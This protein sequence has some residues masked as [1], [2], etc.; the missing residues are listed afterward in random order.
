MLCKLFTT[1]VWPCVSRSINIISALDVWSHWKRFYV[2]KN[3]QRLWQ[4]IN[5]FIELKSLRF[6][7]KY[8]AKW[9]LYSVKMLF[10]WH[11]TFVYF[12]SLHRGLLFGPLELRFCIPRWFPRQI[13][14]SPI[15]D[16]SFPIVVR[17]IPIGTG[18]YIKDFLRVLGFCSILSLQRFRLSVTSILRSCQLSTSWFCQLSATCGFYQYTW[19]LVSF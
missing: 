18:S 1:C 11:S 9:F 5:L 14:T 10:Y 16:R 8:E 15:V 19:D 3:M 2:C 6:S 17:T 4:K 7:L 12:Y 13:P